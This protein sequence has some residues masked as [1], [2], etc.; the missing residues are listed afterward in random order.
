MRFAA[1]PDPVSNEVDEITPKLWIRARI[2][3]AELGG[4]KK[5]PEP[6]NLTPGEVFSAGLNAGRS[7]F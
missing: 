2:F 4:I 6:G 1:Y 7:P 3:M 5:P